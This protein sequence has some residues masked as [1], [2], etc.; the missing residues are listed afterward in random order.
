MLLH[1]LAACRARSS[2]FPEILAV[3][4]HHGLQHAADGWE[5]HCRAQCSLW[6][7]PYVATVVEAA[8]RPGESPEARAREVRYAALRSFMTADAA[9]VTAHHADDQVETVLLQLLRGAG[10]AGLS[11][12][13]AVAALSAGWHFRPLLRFTRADLR[14]YA[15]GELLEW[16][17]DPTN[18]TIEADRNFLRHEIL[19][20]LLHRWPGL[21]GS[22]GRAADLQAQAA[23][24]LTSIAEEDL[25]RCAGSQ[26]ATLSVIALLALPIERRS[27]ALRAWIRGRGFPLPQA[28]QLAQ[29]SR[30]VLEA[31]EDAQPKLHWPGAELRRFR[32]DLH[33]MEPLPNAD[34]SREYMWDASKSLAVEEMVL[35]PEALRRMGW[36][37][38]P[39]RYTVRFRRGGEACRPRGQK[40]HRS[41]KKLFQEHGIPP[42]QRGRVPLIYDGQRLVCVYGYWLCDE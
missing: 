2:N 4:V 10:P 33:V 36:T 24:C 34:P 39:G 12:M 25:V 42:W 40:H 17:E 29:V 27:N 16:V 37:Q 11:A 19:P 30:T 13:P 18:A 31:A 3:H 7:V 38:P 41:L 23:A 5:A 35:E 32:D 15:L 28:R 6:D 20:L 9:L 26:P 21:A 14:A 1:A 8:A 22:V